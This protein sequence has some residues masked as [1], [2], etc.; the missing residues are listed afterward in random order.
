MLRRNSEKSVAARI[1]REEVEFSP[2]TVTK[3]NEVKAMLGGLGELL[4]Q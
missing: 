4:L 1:I 3:H 2:A